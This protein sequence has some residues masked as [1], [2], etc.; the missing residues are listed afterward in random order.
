MSK[1]I[2]PLLLAAGI[3]LTKN[4]LVTGA[5][6]DKAIPKGTPA[7]DAFDQAFGIQ[8]GVMYRGKA[9]LFAGDC[10]RALAG[11]ATLD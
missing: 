4:N 8:T 5:A 9:A 6:L 1:P 11:L 2:Y 10:E 7:R 3:R